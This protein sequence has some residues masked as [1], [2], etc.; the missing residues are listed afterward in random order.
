MA[1][2]LD[3][4]V[5]LISGTGGRIGRECALMFARE[6]AVVV[7]CDF[8][9]G[10]GK[11]TS[12]LASKEGLKVE[13]SPPL[14]MTNEN[15]VESLV[16]RVV[17]EHGKVDILVTAA[18]F[19][20][21]AWIPDMTHEQW[22]TT[23]VAELDITFLLV[24]AVWPHMLE[25]GGGSIINFSSVAAWMGVKGMPS[26]AH[27]AGKGGVLAMTRQMA[28]EGGPHG[29]RANTIAP[30]LVD[31]D[32]PGMELPMPPEFKELM[33]EKHMLSR[34]GKPEDIAYA[35]LYLGSDESS[36]VTGAD[37]RIDG[38]MMAW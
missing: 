35:A 19:T 30:G 36:Y 2:R 26:I 11:E 24:R 18:G 31:S 9:E 37:F 16:K 23:M 13:T 14:D 29:I 28:L 22:R 3:G 15:D 12:K 5:A 21:M 1:G 38:G 27:C 8:D 6:G 7:G 25:N 10:K 32:A 34:L 33:L 20:E 4:K 17:D